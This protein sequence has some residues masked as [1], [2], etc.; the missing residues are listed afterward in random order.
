MRHV[1]FWIL[2]L[3]LAPLTAVALNP[4]PVSAASIESQ[5]AVLLPQFETTMRHL[6][7]IQSQ[8]EVSGRNNRDYDEQ[9]NLWISTVLAVDTTSSICEYENDL[10]S[11]FLDL[12]PHRRPYYYEVRIQS[13][14]TSMQQMRIMQRQVQI[15]VSL[16]KLSP[17]EERIFDK[18]QAETNAAIELLA[19]CQTLIKQ[20]ADQH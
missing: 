13:I 6:E 7:V 12:K 4:A 8:L 10:L 17:N 9:K 15:N 14:A 5:L 3:L 16:L 19:K 2:C 18:I 11:L 1:H 20:L